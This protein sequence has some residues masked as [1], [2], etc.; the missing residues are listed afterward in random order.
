MSHC[1]C[2]DFGIQASLSPLPYRVAVLVNRSWLKN[3][4]FDLDSFPMSGIERIEILPGG[5]VALYGAQADVGAI[6][7]VLRNDFEGIEVEAGS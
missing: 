1:R 7:I 6:D 4:I 3:L 5:P 2:N